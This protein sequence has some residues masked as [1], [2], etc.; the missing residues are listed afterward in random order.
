[1][2]NIIIENKGDDTLLNFLKGVIDRDTKLKLTVGE[3]S[4][5]AFYDLLKEIRR[6]KSFEVILTEDKFSID[7][8]SFSKRYEIARQNQS[9]SGNQY[10]ITLK[11]NMNSTYIARVINTLIQDKVNFKILKPGKNLPSQLI[12]ENERSRDKNVFLPTI[13]NFSSDGIGTQPSNN[14][15][16][17]TAITGDQN[18][19]QSFSNTFDVNWNDNDSVITHT[20]EI[21]DRLSSI[22]SENTPEWLYYVSLYHVFHN[23]LDELDE[24]STIKEGTGFKE[25]T[26]WNTLYDFQKDGVVGL[27]SKLEKYNGAILAD[28]VGLGKTFS[29]LA[30]I[31]Y[32]E[33]RNDKV[34]VLAPKRLRENWTIYTQNDVRNVLADDR[35]N[36]DV[37]NH[38]DL[39]RYD[40]FSGDIDL[41][42]I[43]WGNYDLVV[44][45]ESHNFRNNNPT[46]DDR[47]TRYERLMEE[48]IKKGVNTKVLMLS[49]TPVNNRMNDLK[50]QIAFITND[51]PQALA[52]YG[53]DDLDNELRLAQA[54]YNEWSTLEENQRTTSRFLEMVNPGYFKILDLLTIAR[55]RQHIVKYYNTKEIGEFPKRL[56]PISIKSDID[57]RKNVSSIK[58]V[59]DEIKSLN[60]SIYQQMAYVLP[61]R[62][63]R[64]EKL[65]DTQTSRGVFRQEDRETSLTGLIRVNLLKRLESSIHSFTLTVS[66]MVTQIENILEVISKSQNNEIKLPSLINYDDEEL[67]TAFEDYAVGNKNKILLGDMDLHRWKMDLEEDLVKLKQIQRGASSVSPNRDEKL[68]DLLRLI[69]NKIQNPINEGN[70]KVLIFT[71]FADTAN[72]LYDHVAD[73]VKNKHGLNS[74]L[75]TGG[76]TNKTNMPGIKVTNMEDILVNFSPIS[77]HRNKIDAAASEEIDILIATDTISEGQN[78]QDADYL[79]NYDIH[80]NPVRVVQRFG[81]IDRIG[82]KNTQIQLVNFWP[83]MEL[84]EYINLENRVRGRM[85]LSNVS[86]TGEDDVINEDADKKDMNDMNY[87]RKQMQQ[88]QEQVVDLEDVDGAISV[89]DLTYNEFKSDLS[90]ALKISEK[91]L[92]TAPTG[93]Y[94]ITDADLLDEAE[95]G[96]ILTLKQLSD[97]EKEQTGLYPYLVIYMRQDGSVKLNHLHTNQILSIYKKLAKGKNTVFQSLV[98]QF[99]EETQEGKNMEE[100]SYLLT[101]AIEEI[102]GKTEEVGIQ[103]LFTAGGT[104]FDSADNIQ[105]EDFELISFLIIRE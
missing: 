37:L 7:E 105:I 90:E 30:V 87:R 94:A 66:R 38:T 8:E 36:Y 55:S 81:R 18:I 13:Y 48:I 50:N 9:I 10:E 12:L 86:S 92:V 80:W 78:L 70:K 3:F 103:S 2:K 4:I 39:S 11:N 17:L 84:D 102:K 28:S 32:Y 69:D 73:Y 85:V 77:K 104:H 41:K 27:I 35:F 31:K 83:N 101:Q 62:K 71:A 19:V 43:N 63:S 96:I 60:L 40:G 44:I 89:T 76:G 58:E 64:Y 26:V 61:T 54:R 59:N 15:A 72:Y 22:S 29:A 52:Q 65:Y 34:L 24:K 98:D 74:A 45:D 49:A 51:N 46:K 6:A 5:Y 91:E 99:N 47:M 33:L 21:I 82:S 25:T 14:L 100:Y 20:D 1:M 56:K 16:P 97:E 68:N 42:T 88:L 57:T 93:M 53:I 67:E 95:P 75:I 23:Q 79:V